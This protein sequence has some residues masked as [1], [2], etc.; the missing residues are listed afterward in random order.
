MMLCLAET[1]RRVLRLRG[2]PIVE[3][4]ELL[5]VLSPWNRSWLSPD[6][7][8][9]P[10]IGRQSCGLRPVEVLPDDR[11]WLDTIDDVHRSDFPGSL[12]VEVVLVGRAIGVDVLSEEQTAERM[13]P[14]MDFVPPDRVVDPV[15]STR[16]DTARRA[17]YQPDDP[18]A[19]IDDASE[20]RTA[21]L[22]P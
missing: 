18:H 13:H 7:S 17:L 5:V 22:V 3:V 11:V 19:S 9:A 10:E 15:D 14:Q 2:H 21:G 1:T 8:E 4:I 16:R 12:R 6:G 20:D